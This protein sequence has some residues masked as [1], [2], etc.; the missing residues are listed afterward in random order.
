MKDLDVALQIQEKDNNKLNVLKNNKVVAKC[1]YEYKANNQVKLDIKTKRFKKVCKYLILSS[2]VNHLMDENSD[3]GCFLVSDS[4]IEQ[5]EGI[6]Q[7]VIPN[8]IWTS[9]DNREHL[10]YIDGKMPSQSCLE[11][12]PHDKKIYTP[13][14]KFDFYR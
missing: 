2:I 11:C 9:N 3:L 14:K 7:M 4:L 8:Y 13:T 6:R 5:C 10:S 12:I 1:S